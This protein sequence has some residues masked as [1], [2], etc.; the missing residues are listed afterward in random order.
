[1][2]LTNCLIGGRLRPEAKRYSAMKTILHS[3]NLDRVD[4]NKAK[5]PQPILP[6]RFNSTSEPLAAPIL[7]PE[8]N[9]VT[10]PSTCCEAV[11]VQRC[12]E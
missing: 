3:T 11:H 7:P 1:M 5:E 10:R 12:C 6:D 4:S 9:S 8:F 2:E